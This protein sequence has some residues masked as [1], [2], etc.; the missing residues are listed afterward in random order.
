MSTAPRAFL[1][2]GIPPAKRPPSCG[3]VAIADPEEASG[4]LG[5]VLALL[6]LLRARP[7]PGG[8]G[9]M[10]REGGLARPEEGVLL[11]VLL[12]TMGAL[13]SL[14]TALRRRVPPEA[15]S[16]RRAPWRC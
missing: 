6:L 11:L 5:V 1:S 14:V 16:P 7:A 3:A 10:P 15:M 9:G 4:G 13:R 8:R 12:A 2:L